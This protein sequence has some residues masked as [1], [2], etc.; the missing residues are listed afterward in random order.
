MT[1][2]EQTSLHSEAEEEEK[3]GAEGSEGG[4]VSRSGGG[5]GWC[6]P[7]ER[8][9]AGQLEEVLVRAMPSLAPDPQLLDIV[10]HFT[11]PKVLVLLLVY[12]ALCY[13]CMWYIL[14]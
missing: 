6:E 14:A 3:E 9:S 8:L 5:G 4:R 13:S 7:L 11:T 12:A 2:I 1:L 10:L